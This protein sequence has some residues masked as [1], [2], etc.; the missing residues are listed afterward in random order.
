MLRLAHGRSF[1]LHNESGL[2]SSPIISRIETDGWA[3]ARTH[4]FKEAFEN[5]SLA[6]ILWLVR[7]DPIADDFVL[8]YT[9]DFDITRHNF[10]DG[11]L[12]LG[13]AGMWK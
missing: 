6:L 10:N 7:G 13:E 2:S 9:P 5:V 3:R 4:V 8:C 12:R 1:L 11:S